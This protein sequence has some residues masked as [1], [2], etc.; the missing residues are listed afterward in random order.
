[1]PVIIAPAQP[2]EYADFHRGYI[3]A[4]HGEPDAIG[5]LERQQRI[6]DRMRDL[7]AEQAG[8]RY[9]E[10]KWTVRDII[11]HLS[12]AERIVA[13]R[14][15]RIA[16]GDATPLPGFDEQAYAAS[17]NA[18]RRP[19]GELV[20]ELSVVRASTLALVHSLDES[21]LGR[22]GT[23]NNWTLSVRALAFIIP[24]HLQHH[25]NVLRDRYGVTL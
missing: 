17:A 8:F 21:V 9:A 2:D 10:G 25:V 19:L 15:L 3:A 16:R 13:Y 4:V 6:I 12:D 24:G 18:G 23:V 7:S 14:L 22:R 11:A 20:D 5:L 1:M